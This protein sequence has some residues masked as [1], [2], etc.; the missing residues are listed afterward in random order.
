MHLHLQPTPPPQKKLKSSY[1]PGHDTK[2]HS[3]KKTTIFWRPCYR[4]T[5]FPNARDMSDLKD[6]D[7]S[8][9]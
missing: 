7:S 1:R 6:I 5:S 2:Q 8:S 4:E 9:L 3:K